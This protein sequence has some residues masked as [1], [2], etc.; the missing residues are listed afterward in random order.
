LPRGFGIT[1][2]SGGGWKRRNPGAVPPEALERLR[3][4]AALRFPFASPDT[5]P[6]LADGDD[7]VVER[8]GG[9]RG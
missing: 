9:P 1:A 2:S 8:D 6:P 3:E 4:V 5:S 7:A